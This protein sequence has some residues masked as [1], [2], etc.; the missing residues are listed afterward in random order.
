MDP[1]SV[2]GLVANI[3]QLIDAAGNAF[4]VCHQIH[5]SGR[6]IDDTRMAFTS[7][8]LREAY[9]DLSKSLKHGYN[10]AVP[11]GS[12]ANLISLATQC[13]Q[14]A[15]TLQVELDA[16]QKAPGS[17]LHGTIEKAW[18]KKRK[19]K[20][21]EKL[22]LALDEYEKTM[23]SKI[24]IIVRQLLGALGEKQEGQSKQLLQISHDLKDCQLG[25][26]AQLT[27]EIDSCIIANE[28]QHV[29]TREHVT[30]TMRDLNLS[31]TEQFSE[32]RRQQ[33]DQQQYD[34]FFN[35]LWFREM[36]TRM[37]DVEESHPH[38]FHWMFEE[39]LS[40]PWDSFPSWLQGDGRLYWINGKA[41][42]GKSTLMKFLIN[43][44]RTRDL[45][46]EWSS[47]K[48]PLIVAF[49]FWLSGSEMQRSFK[50]FL[51]SIVYQLVDEERQLVTK[52]LRGNTGLLSKEHPGDWSKQELQRLLAQIIG[53]LD[54]PL[55]IFLDGL[56]EFDQEDDL[57]QL[58]N[59]VE[60]SS[61]SG[62]IKFCI[63]SRPEH[64]I[65]K[66]MS[67]YRQLRLQD[68][69]ARDMALCIRTKLE[70]TRAQCRPASIDDAYL[71]WIISIIAAKADGVFLWVYYA[72]SS[73]IR[74]MRNEDDFGVLLGRIEALPN[75]MHQL[76]LQMWNRLNEDQQHYQEEAATYFSYVAACFASSRSPPL[77]LFEMLVALDPQLQRSILDELKP[78]DPISLARE[79]ELLQARIITRSAGLLELSMK[80][81]SYIDCRSSA[82]SSQ[83]MGTM[84]DNESLTGSPFHQSRE[85]LY[86]DS[87]CQSDAVSSPRRNQQNGI[88][89]RVGTHSNEKIAFIYD[90]K[91]NYLHR[92]AR[93]FLST[94]EGLRLSGNPKDPPVTRSHNIVRARMTCLVQGLVKFRAYEI[95]ILIYDIKRQFEGYPVPKD[96]T[97]SLILLRRLCQSLSTPGDPQHHIGYTAFWGTGNQ[98]FECIAARY[99]CM[100]YVKEFV[101]NRTSYIDP[102]RRGLLAL[103][104]VLLPVTAT[105]VPGN[106]ALFSWLAS[107]GADVH[108]TYIQ[109]NDIFTPASEFLLA[110]DNSWIPKDET[111]LRQFCDSLH[112]ILPYP[113]AR[114]GHCIIPLSFDSNGDVVFG[115]SQLSMP[116]W[117]LSEGQAMVRMSLLKLCYLVTERL[118]K[119]LPFVPQWSRP[120]IGEEPL[121]RVL[122]IGPAGERHRAGNLYTH[123]VSPSETDST[124]LSEALERILFSG[125]VP[126]SSIRA[127]FEYIHARLDEVCERSPEWIEEDWRYEHIM[128]LRKDGQ[129][130]ENFGLDL[131][132]LGDRW[133][134]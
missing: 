130:A 71:E 104:A 124:Y 5:A 59:L 29:V 37:N 2:L 83:S 26:A 15:K 84:D 77:S 12:G 53:L 43:D 92:T 132:S 133:Y 81:S 27:S 58:L 64:Y 117:G 18:L 119:R 51:C 120:D 128:A 68:L 103:H 96:E 107:N 41:G 90:T 52:L 98:S 95:R 47:G 91:I 55:C 61:V 70:A 116:P 45:L 50:G 32:Q 20:T 49:Y 108:M 134:V 10:T 46:A 62:M 80:V 89:Y 72:L 125:S 100:E 60:D 123:G 24:L 25:F 22:K 6:S 126:A 9:G 112:A 66:R 97:E 118:Q 85:S 56:D 87:A 11:V 16:L 8:Q 82:I 13:C 63:S 74:G 102:C 99:G 88:S 40:R 7:E 93:D 57:D 36:H 109:G 105:V 4:T 54:R 110:I 42:S 33:H 19:A 35:S 65:V 44:P 30:T 115:L 127:L 1:L 122:L 101:E 48:S 76:Y 121:T 39:N 78:Q 17:G 3:V 67:K 31:H 111:D 94:E 106:M 129:L 113:G 131:E 86:G 73:L 79:C 75:G 114:C 21:I 23:D 69:T 28:A 14:T 34:R 38:T